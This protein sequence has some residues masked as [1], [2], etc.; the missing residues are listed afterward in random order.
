[1]LRTVMLL[2]HERRTKIVVERCQLLLS[3]HSAIT[4]GVRDQGGLHLQQG[5]AEGSCKSQQLKIR[6]AN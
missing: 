2:K 6:R 1:M 4:A 5:Q 3:L